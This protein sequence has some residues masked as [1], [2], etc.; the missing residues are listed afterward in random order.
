LALHVFLAVLLAAVLHASWNLIVKLDMDRFLAL[1]LIQ[2]LMGVMGLAM[3]LVFPLAAPQSWP[4]ALA[5]GL[6]HLG[7][8]TFLARSYR[9][10]DLSQV[11][12]IARGTAPLLTF[13]AAW[14]LAGEAVKPVTALGIL[15][16]V[17]GIWLTARRSSD[18]L[19]LDGMTMMFALGTSVFI[20]VYTLVDG[21]GARASGSVGSY[22][23]LV[24]VFDALFL[25]IY[26]IATRGPGIIRQVA[27]SWKIGSL[28]AA[29]SAGAY[30]IVMWA[31]SVA[32]IAAVAALRETSI[33]FVM[34][35]SVLV[36]K[37]KVTILR[38]IGALVIVAGAV[39]LRL[40]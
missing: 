12:P 2:V 28:G 11:Y 35:M 36:L 21:L 10:G 39:A 33:L 1:F 3:L 6:I 16:L 40:A 23:G 25:L 20:A 29:L 30:W 9:T 17:A 31:M 32:P 4:Y 26:G 24:F 37:E 18:S 38:G 34:V 27:P 5:S 22:A 8:N 14:A 15:L 19:R 7:Y 13:I